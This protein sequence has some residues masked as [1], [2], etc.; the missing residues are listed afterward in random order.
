MYRW[1]KKDYLKLMEILIENDC[2]IFLHPRFRRGLDRTQNLFANQIIREAQGNVAY[3]SVDFDVNEELSDTAFW[4][5]IDNTK[6]NDF[7]EENAA[8]AIMKMAERFNLMNQS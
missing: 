8:A 3:K 7:I 5:R 2:P 6:Y 1:T 4:N